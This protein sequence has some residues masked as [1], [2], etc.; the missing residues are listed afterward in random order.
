MAKNTTSIGYCKKCNKPFEKIGKGS[1]ARK[2]CKLCAIIS[3]RASKRKW[4][5]RKLYGTDK[6]NEYTAKKMRIGRANGTIQDSWNDRQLGSNMIGK[7][8]ES[9]I[10]IVTEEII[11]PSD[12]EWEQYHRKIKKLKRETI[13]G[14][15]QMR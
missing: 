6:Y 14:F 2:Y 10:D 15:Q 12:E 1:G 4:I 3:G 9:K 11:E 13:G 8:P 5:K 7:P